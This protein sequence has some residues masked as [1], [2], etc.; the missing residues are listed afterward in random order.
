MVIL[1]LPQSIHIVHIYIHCALFSLCAAVHC[2]RLRNWS[3]Y[4]VDSDSF[5]VWFC[6]EY[7][8][9]LLVLKWKMRREA[10]SIQNAM[11]VKR[12][13]TQFNNSLA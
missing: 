10:N 3:C 9:Y 11:S 1:I 7:I 6:V 8:E 13:E 12:I 5:L 2:S 4:L